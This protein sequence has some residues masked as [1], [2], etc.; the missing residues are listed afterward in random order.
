MDAAVNISIVVL[1]GYGG[2]RLVFD[3]LSV[4]VK[5]YIWNKSAD[6]N[7]WCTEVNR[8]PYDPNTLALF[9]NGPKSVH[10]VSK[11]YPTKHTRRFG[12]CITRGKSLFKL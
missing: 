6:G 5:C 9:I 11:R 4:L 3:V 2:I 1:A 8:L 12:V 10:G 7:E